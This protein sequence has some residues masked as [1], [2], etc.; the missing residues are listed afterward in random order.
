M[1]Q[2]K[3]PTLFIVFLMPEQL[4]GKND[5]TDNKN[6]KANPVYPVHIPYPFRFGSIRIRFPDKKILRYLS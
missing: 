3:L 5:Q 6:E 1:P 2:P 4:N